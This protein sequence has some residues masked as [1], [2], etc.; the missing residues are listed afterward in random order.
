MGTRQSPEPKCFRSFTK[1]RM[2]VE[3]LDVKTCDQ[4]RKTQENKV[5][6]VHSPSPRCVHSSG[7]LLSNLRE[8]QR[9]RRKVLRSAVWHARDAQARSCGCCSKPRLP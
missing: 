2:R 8:A 1:P 6:W 4:Q 3:S 7:A 5:V 9:R